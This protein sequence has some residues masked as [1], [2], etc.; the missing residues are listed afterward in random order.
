MHR[1]ATYRL[2]IVSTY[3]P[4]RC[5]L[6][7][8]TA[9]LREALGVA[10]DDVETV[11][12]AT[13]RDGLT[14]GDEVVA[15]INQDRIEDY[16]AAADRMA[17]AGVQAVLIQ[18][19]YGIF[20]GP[21][22]SHVL[23]LARAL[24]ERGIPYLVTL[25]TLLSRPTA[26][27]AA[28]L[29]ALCAR[30][31]RVTVFTE[32]ARKIAIRTGVAAGHQIHV[33][34]HGGP[35]A[36][37]T[38]PPPATVSEP[39]RRLLTAL[40]DAPTLTTFGLVS[41]GKGIDDAITA[42][43]A[44]V[45]KH[46]ETQ[47]VVAGATHP[48]IVR[49]DGESYRQS[50]HDQVA[51]LGLVDNVHFLDSFLSLAD[52]SA[53]LRRTTIFVTP[54][55]SPEQ[56][57][58]GALTFAVTA[59]CPV[60]S[61]AYR[62][63]ED[64]LSGGAGVLVPCNDVAGLAAAITGLLD[65]PHALAAAKDTADA[66]GAQLTWPA[67]ALRVA[68]LVREVVAEA[69]A[70]VGS[71]RLAYPAGVVPPLR[72]DHLVKL[73]DEI[74][75][76]EFCR[77][78]EPDLDFGYNVDDVARLAI[79]AADLLA[80]GRGGDVA[81]RW[82]RLAMRFLIAAYQPWG[83]MRNRLSY[84]GTWQDEPHLGDHV[85]R[86]VW[87]LGVLIGTPA[88]P[89]EVR[90]SAGALLD[91][92]APH[93]N[94]LA[95]CGLRSAAYALLGLVRAERAT[96]QVAQLVHRLDRALRTTTAVDP[97]W[98]WFEPEL[99][100][101]N[102]R[103]PQAM[104][105]GATLLGE[106]DVAARALSALDWYVD[107]VALSTGTMHCVGNEWH[108]RGQHPHEWLEDGDEQP[109]DAG[110][111]V[112]ALVEAWRNTGDARYVRLAGWAYAWF[113]GRNRAGTRLYDESAGSCHDGLSA[114]DAN[115]NRGAESTL[116]YHQAV[117]ALLR[118]GLAKLPDRRQA[119]RSAEVASTD[120]VSPERAVL[121]GTDRAGTVRAPERSS[122]RPGTRASTRS[123]TRPPATGTRATEGQSDAR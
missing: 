47:Y 102:A 13:D 86:A 45:Q 49:R 28:T 62:Y 19:E 42:L 105:A 112:E 8:F 93:T 57:C 108:Y 30:A 96:P 98:R 4:R 44:V 117:L 67:V 58:S 118:A 65:D 109:I 97:N 41:A 80:V 38:S 46:P 106:H 60:V 84:R 11:I 16:E 72:L 99:T 12:V 5:G 92:L 76:I 54:Y 53:L 33:V 70:A 52:L 123:T 90:R 71:G 110:S 10:T 103:L 78:D 114:T 9:D 121:A 43:A 35:I 55:R 115:P 51:R 91:E 15:T 20:G 29:S 94:A 39:V 111:T 77:G 26:G 50:L 25:H 59:G 75:I 95:E 116:A 48:E 82:V 120:R 88:V 37:R 18:H 22:G 64:L 17:A 81:Q 2:G 3:L 6:A 34:P 40:G 69:G 66:L 89:V 27:Q 63:A 56:I 79:V 23:R 101:D 100:Y 73:T 31:A 107:H 68:D 36:L 113:H 122:V 119:A 24:N 74:G 83:G 21:N 14:Y 85:A 87:A 7:T 32:T 61:T 1:A 104:L